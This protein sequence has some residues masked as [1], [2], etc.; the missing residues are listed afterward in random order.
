[1]A[2]SIVDKEDF[3]VG[4]FFFLPFVVEKQRLSALKH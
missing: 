1:M 3:Q 4:G 2:V